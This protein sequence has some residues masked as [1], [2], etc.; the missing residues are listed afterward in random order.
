[1]CTSTPCVDLVAADIFDNPDPVKTSDGAITY[2]GSIVNVGDSPVDPT[3]SWNIDITYTGPG[4]PT[5]SV[6]DI[7][8][9]MVVLNAPPIH[10]VRCTSKAT[11][12]D[13]MDLGAGAGVTF[14]VDVTGAGSAGTATLEVELDQTSPAITEF[15]EGNN[16]LTETTAITS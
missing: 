16:V 2:T 8:Q 6:P 11:G 7:S 1:V 15:D 5:L 12:P 13:W 14:T 9:C 3:A 4:S 10:H